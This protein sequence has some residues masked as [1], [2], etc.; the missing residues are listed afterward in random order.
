MIGNSVFEDCTSIKE[1]TIPESVTEIGD[2]A[3]EKCTSLE[4]ITIHEGVTKIGKKAFNGCTSLTTVTL[5]AGVRNMEHAFA[6]NSALS[7]IYVPSKK[8]DYY[9][10]HLPEE[11]HDKIVELKPEKKT[12]EC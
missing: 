5:P 1:I 8:S 2:Y 6:E 10:K 4:E 9:K 11:L 3:F 12:R 7:T